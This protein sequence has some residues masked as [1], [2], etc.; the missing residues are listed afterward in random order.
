[1]RPVQWK[2]GT[3]YFSIKI[4]KANKTYMP[5]SYNI[6]FNLQHWKISL[7]LAVDITL[8]CFFFTVPTDIQVVICLLSLQITYLQNMIHRRS[9]DF[10][11]VQSSTPFFV[12]TYPH[13]TRYYYEILHFS[14]Y[15]YHFP[16]ACEWYINIS[17][18]QTCVG[19][20]LRILWEYTAGLPW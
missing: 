4:I 5:L 2:R 3:K 1:M 14:G 16:C 9:N 6:S 7:L 8:F 13:V 15:D 20:L 10:T 19:S 17:H 11:A 12:Q 18:L